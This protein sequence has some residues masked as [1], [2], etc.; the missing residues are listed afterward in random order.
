[1]ITH[2]RSRTTEAF[3]SGVVLSC[4]VSLPGNVERTG[5]RKMCDRNMDGE[6]TIAKAHIFVLHIFVPAVLS[7][8]FR[9]RRTDR[10]Q[11]DV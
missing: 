3:Y 5:D 1:M 6:V 10:G 2:M 4:V 7:F 8:L 9:Q 11:K